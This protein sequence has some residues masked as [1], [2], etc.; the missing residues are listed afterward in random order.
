MKH[1]YKIQKMLE[2]IRPG[3]LKE[4][5]SNDASICGGTWTSLY[6][7]TKVNDLDIFFKNVVDYVS[8][9]IYMS[10]NTTNYTHSFESINAVSYLD[11]FSGKKIQLIKKRY[12]DTTEIINEFDFICCMCGYSFK[13]EKMYY[14]ED[15]M[16]QAKD[17]RVHYNYKSTSGVIGTLIRVQ[18]YS[19]R[20]FVVNPIDVTKIALKVNELNFN[21]FQD[22]LDEVE[23]YIYYL[24]NG[25][26][27]KVLKVHRD[28]EFSIP[29]F[30]EL[31]SKVEHSDIIRDD[32]TLWGDPEIPNWGK[33]FKGEVEKQILEEVYKK[34]EVEMST[35]NPNI[36]F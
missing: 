4:L 17:K 23:S 22:L 7:N 20:G 3:L 21:T 24:D 19:A 18:K 1:Q 16:K 13:E 6:S 35:D 34:K 31:V 27:L 28:E 10:V 14:H 30:L 32:T 2:L 12:G 11:N 8:M 15:F 36:P 5:I 26:T 25:K 33:G 9:K 29:K